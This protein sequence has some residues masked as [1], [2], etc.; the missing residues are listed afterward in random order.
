MSQ[1][2]VPNSSVEAKQAQAVQAMQD[3]IENVKL[4]SMRLWSGIRSYTWTDVNQYKWEEIKNGRR[5]D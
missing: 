2:I 3:E 1:T 4:K 5:D